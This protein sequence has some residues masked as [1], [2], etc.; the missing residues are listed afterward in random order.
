MVVTLLRSV[1]LIRRRSR[2]DRRQALLARSGLLAA[3]L[4][5]LASIGPVPNAEASCAPLIQ[6]CP[7]PGPPVVRVE[8]SDSD[9]SEH[10]ATLRGTIDPDGLATSYHFAWGRT[11]YDHLTG[12][13]RIAA[14]YGAQN[15]STNIGGL[16][17]KT[18]YQF[19]LVA[20]NADGTTSAEN[21][22]ITAAP[23]K[24]NLKVA[25]PRLSRRTITFG[26]PLQVNTYVYGGLST[27]LHY[28]DDSPLAFVS[29]KLDWLQ[30]SGQNPFL[31]ASGPEAY[32]TK[33]GRLS[34]TV[35]PDHNTGV[36]VG[37]EDTEGTFRAHSPSAPVVV[38]PAVT[39]G[40][41]RIPNDQRRAIISYSARVHVLHRGYRLPRVYFYTAPSRRSRLVLRG[42]R[43]LTVE[44]FTNDELDLVSNLTFIDTHGFVAAACVRHR[45]V[46]DM[47]TAFFAPACGRRVLR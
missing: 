21:G 35:S 33:S 8:V 46:A 22:I 28:Y 30:Y 3:G 41:G 14:G 25:R 26:Q 29:G 34:F 19:E 6:N 40:A 27:W 1:G 39:V 36:S 24:P 2:N 37:L 13:A 47:G 45:L 43:R 31:L 7:T 42:S 18:G 44:V 16:A 38:S 11:Q 20:T 5:A 10:T 12:T 4:T 32:V 9:V 17:P 15:V 23:P